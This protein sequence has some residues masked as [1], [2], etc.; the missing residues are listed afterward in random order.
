MDINGVLM[1]T[2]QLMQLLEGEGVGKVVG[3][4]PEI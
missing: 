1:I 4:L 3:C 2:V